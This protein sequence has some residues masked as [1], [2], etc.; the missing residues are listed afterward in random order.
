[1]NAES[2]AQNPSPVLGKA[3]DMGSPTLPSHE[4]LKGHTEVRITH[5]GCVYSLRVTRQGKLILTK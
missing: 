5:S 2:N 1:M 4:I 3:G